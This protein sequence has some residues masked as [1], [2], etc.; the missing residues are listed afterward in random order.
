[1]ELITA[2][3]RAIARTSDLIYWS[4]KLKDD[5]DLNL[6]MAPEID[7]GYWIAREIYNILKPVPAKLIKDCGVRTIEIKYLGRN[8]ECYPNHGWFSNSENL[9][10]LNSD[11]F[12][13]P[14]Y[15]EDFSDN[16]GYSLSRC[17]ETLLHELS[18]SSD[19]S[20]GEPSLKPEWLSLSGWSKEPKP[21]L[22][23]MTINEPGMPPKVGEWY[24][25]PKASFVRFYAKMAPWEDWADSMAFFIS[26][27][28]DKVPPKKAAYF[29]NILRAYY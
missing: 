10:V 2:S 15:P 3:L 20:K 24:Y 11:I 25:D 6:Q 21:G 1:M 17:Q 23:R 4:K 16:R 26:G 27:M 7:N 5:F 8:R 22:K 13:H 14:D 28:K 19:A 9:I 12:I 29:T 18:H